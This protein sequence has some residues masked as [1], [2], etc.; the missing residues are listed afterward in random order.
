MTM[1]FDLNLQMRCAVPV[2]LSATGSVDIGIQHLWIAMTTKK[3]TQVAL[4]ST[5]STKPALV[6]SF[7]ATDEE[8]VAIES[9]E[10]YAT[11]EHE[12][13]YSEDTVWMS[14]VKSE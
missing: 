4:V 8:V 14:T 11:V 13:A 9:V 2:F 7:Q 12:N 5:Q 3:R 1:T 6:E 10:G